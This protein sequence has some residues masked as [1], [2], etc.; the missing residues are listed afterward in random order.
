MKNQV[1]TLSGGELQK[2]NIILVIASNPKVIFLDE[3]TTGLDYEAKK[4]IIS[5]IKKYLEKSKITLIFITH[6]LEEILQLAESVYFLKQGKIVEYGK[7]DD[8][9]SKYKLEDS[10]ICSLYE[11]VIVN[12]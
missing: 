4:E 7:L 2:L 5:Y 12:V 8:L 1:N 3:M 9:F 11:E 10:N 6:Y